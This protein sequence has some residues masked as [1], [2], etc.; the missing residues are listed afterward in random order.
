MFEHPTNWQAPTGTGSPPAPHEVPETPRAPALSLVFGTVGVAL[1]FVPILGMFAMP[2]GILATLFG[3]AGL[4]ERGADD[5]LQRAAAI[6]GLVLAASAI[7]LAVGGMRLMTLD[8]DTA[9]GMTP[10]RAPA[11]M[12][13]HLVSGA[14]AS[15]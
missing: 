7:V 6:S 10:V 4:V 11:D 9:G 12:A 2:L 8:V 15:G 3:L 14:E 1:S 5:P 13:G